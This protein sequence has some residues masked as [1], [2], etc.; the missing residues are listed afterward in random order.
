MAISYYRKTSCGGV[1]WHFGQD[2]LIILLLY[3]L[4]HLNLILIDHEY[5]TVRL[6]LTIV[7]LTW[8]I[9]IQ[10]NCLLVTPH[11]IQQQTRGVWWLPPAVLLGAASWAEFIRG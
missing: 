7:C 3:I 6:G 8:Q 11:C 5:T 2:R 4:C 1:L 10:S 9:T